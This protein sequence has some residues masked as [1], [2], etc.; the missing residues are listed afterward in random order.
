[1]QVSQVFVEAVVCDLWQIKRKK[2]Y[3]ENPKRNKLKTCDM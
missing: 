3:R 1:M 2:T